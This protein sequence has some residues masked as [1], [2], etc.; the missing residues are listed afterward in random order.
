MKSR[1]IAVL[2][3]TVLLGSSLEAVD[4]P[5]VENVTAAQRAGTKIV[6]ISYD[7]TLDASEPSAFVEVW[8]SY[9]NGRTFP[10]PA[11]SVT[12]DVNAGQA[13]G[14]GKTAEWDASIDWDQKFTEKGKIRIIATY[15]AAPSGL[16]AGHDFGD[17]GMIALEWTTL[18]LED[19][20]QGAGFWIEDPWPADLFT[21]YGSSL[22]ILRV[23]PAEITND[24]WNEVAQWALSNGYDGLPIVPD[25]E[26][27]SLPVTNINFFQAIKW[28]NARSEKDG[29][30]PAYY[31]DPT[32]VIGD[33]NGN[34]TIENGADNFT[35]L[36]PS[37]DLNMNGKW[38]EGEPFTDNNGNSVYDG[39]EYADLN[40]NS[41]VDLGLT[42]PYRTGASIPDWGSNTLSASGLNPVYS[43]IKWDA[44]GY[45]LP[46]TG[47][48]QFLIVAGSHQKNW[49]WGDNLGSTETLTAA[50]II[51]STSPSLENTSPL[52][53]TNRGT[54][55]FGIK[56]IIGNVAEWSEDMMV[57][58]N[59]PATLKHVV[60]GGSY[61]GLESAGNYNEQTQ[62]VDGEFV[63]SNNP[64][65]DFADLYITGDGTVGT[66]AIGLRTVRYK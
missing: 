7:L 50:G 16:G 51:S 64:S 8:F 14:V 23:D 59:N 56:D 2:A 47:I 12:G 29:L 30:Q 33:L 18:Y 61:Q 17:S 22:D 4:P 55:P 32:E 13:T 65:N 19:P 44:Q 45:R 27:G 60:Y 57:D 1:T 9:D 28:C 31:T 49:P 37:E 38:D 48:Q 36:N 39:I 66:Q 10:I 41:Q 20:T 6:D 58:I 62:V 43:F 3:T 40:T 34:G 5:K 11:T 63:N 53:A 42:T 21:N 26:D 25:T 54:N 52:A 46:L 15:G 35:P 24:Q